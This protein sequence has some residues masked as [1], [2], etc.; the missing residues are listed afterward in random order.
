MTCP[1]F[2]LMEYKG[3]I[4]SIADKN[5]I[6]LPHPRYIYNLKDGA[7]SSSIGHDCVATY[8]FVDDKLCIRSFVWRPGYKGEPKEKVVSNDREIMPEAKY[9]LVDQF[10]GNKWEH[11]VKMFGG[12]RYNDVNY[13]IYR[14][15]GKML[16]VRHEGDN[17]Q[18]KIR[19]VLTI[20]DSKVVDDAP[21]A[22]GSDLQGLL[23][24]TCY[25]YYAGKGY[26]ELYEEGFSKEELW[27]AGAR[28]NMFEPGDY[29]RYLRWKI[30][31]YG[32]KKCEKEEKAF[33]E[34][35]KVLYGYDF[36]EM[37]QTI[38]N[39]VNG[40]YDENSN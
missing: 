18:K 38:E 14:V 9:Y 5:D 35:I 13:P 37:L 20:E 15:S 1:T 31:I 24:R 22:P 17:Y 3:H 32:K 29:E 39:E 25:D 7:W 10:S 19:H 8:G 40:G 16:I 4:Y 27:E 12:W 34:M 11:N 30:K 21:W 28:C 2:S 23:D 6:A 33:K 36:D 26:K